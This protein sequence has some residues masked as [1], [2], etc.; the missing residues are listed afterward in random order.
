MSRKIAPKPSV[1]LT[2]EE[3]TIQNTTN[4]KLIITTYQKRKYLRSVFMNDFLNWD[5]LATYTGALTMVG[6]LTQLTKNIPFIKKIPTQ[7]WS[8]ILSL[9]IIFPATIFSSGLTLSSAVL[10]FFNSA[11]VSLASNGGFDA[12]KKFIDKKEM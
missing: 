5:I 9:I 8:Y 7:I 2:E 12:L 1:S 6:F 11:I 10:I 3:R 4:G